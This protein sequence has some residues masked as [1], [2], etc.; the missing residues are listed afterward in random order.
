MATQ[1]HGTEVST[2]SQTTTRFGGDTSK[3]SAKTTDDA[4]GASNLSELDNVSAK[5]NPNPM[6][7]VSCR[8]IR[9]TLIL[10]NRDRCFRKIV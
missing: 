10:I 5:M 6:A 8:S 7:A 3:G 4:T 1:E 2:T 9:T